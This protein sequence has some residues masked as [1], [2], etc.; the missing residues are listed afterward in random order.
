VDRLKQNERQPPSLPKY[1]K[2]G[3]KKLK[4]PEP[5]WSEISKFYQVM[6]GRMV[7]VCSVGDDDLTWPV[8][9]LLHSRTIRMSASWNHGRKMIAIL[10][11][12][13]AIPG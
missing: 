8:F 6:S 11:F 12:G 13:I 9:P 10:T 3:F 1:T 5:A 7:V 2:V 4:M